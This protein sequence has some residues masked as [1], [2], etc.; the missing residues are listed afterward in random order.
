MSAICCSYFFNRGIWRQLSRVPKNNFS[1]LKSACI[2][3]LFGSTTWAQEEFYLKTYAGY[4]D[5]TYYTRGDGQ[6]PTAAEI[7]N[8]MGVFQDYLGNIYLTESSYV[9]Q[10]SENSQLIINT[11]AGGGTSPDDNGIPATS[12][13]LSTP[14]G[15]AG[16]LIGNIYFS[17]ST[18]CTVRYI[19]PT[20]EIQTLLG[21][22]GM[23]QGGGA[24]YLNGPRGLFCDVLASKLYI[25]DRLNYVVKSYDLGT[26]TIDVVLGSGV[27]GS[28]FSV[29][30]LQVSIRPNGVFRDRYDRLFVTD[31]GS[32]RVII[33]EGGVASILVGDGITDL[34][35]GDGGPAALAT[36]SKSAAVCV[37]R[38]DIVY[39]FS[40][41]SVR[42]VDFSGQ[43]DSI[44]NVTSAVIAHDEM[45][46]TVR[47]GSPS[48]CFVTPADEILF[49]DST[50]NVLWKL[51]PYGHSFSERKLFSVV[52]YVNGVVLP[53]T[54]V[55]LKAIYGVWGDSVGNIYVTDGQSHRVHRIYVDISGETVISVYAGTGIG[56]YNGDSKAASLAS[57]NYPRAI[58][59]NTNGDIFIA[60]T[61]GHRIRSVSAGVIRTIAGTG[62]ASTSD[63]SDLD[64]SIASVT[65]IKSPTSVSVSPDG[66]K[67]FFVH[68]E[69]SI[70]Y[71]NVMSDELIYVSGSKNSGNL[72]TDSTIL[73]AR[74]WYLTLYSHASNVLFTGELNG[75]KVR[76]LNFSIPIVKLLVGNPSGVPLDDQLGTDTLLNGIP[77]ICGV[78]KNKLYF[79][80]E[81]ANKIRSLDL[82]TNVVTTLYGSGGMDF[83]VAAENSVV[84]NT[85]DA[86]P[87]VGCHYS[88]V[89]DAFY[90]TEFYPT[91]SSAGRLRR[92]A[93]VQVP[94]SQPSSKP[95]QQPSSQPTSAPT[96]IFSG[97]SDGKQVY[98]HIGYNKQRA[99]TFG[100]GEEAIYARLT[101]FRDFSFDPDNN[102]V[103]PD[104]LLIRKLNPATGIISRVAGGGSATNTGDG[105]DALQA[106][107]VN[108]RAVTVDTS[109]NIYY[110]ENDMYNRVRMLT[111]STNVINTIVGSNS[112]SDTGY[113]GDSGA[114]TSAK[115]NRPWGIQY[116]EA[117]HTLFIAEWNNQVIR[118]YDIASDL[119]STIAGNGSTTFSLAPGTTTFTT[120]LNGPVDVWLGNDDFVYI[121]EYNGC[122]IAR[123][124]SFSNEIFRFAGTGVC[125]DTPMQG[126]S[127][128]TSLSNPIA[129]CGDSLGNIYIADRV[130]LRRVNGGTGYMEIVVSNLGDNMKSPYN[131][132]L[133][134]SG[135]ITGCGVHKVTGTL[136][137]ASSLRSLLKIESPLGPSP[138]VEAVVGFINPICVPA[139][140][141]GL[142]FNI[143]RIWS[144][145]V[146]DMYMIE[147]GGS[148]VL[149]YS[150]AFDNVCVFAGL[151]GILTVT[152]A[153]NIPATSS[154]LRQ[155]SALVG[156]VS[157][158]IYV[159][160]YWGNRIR[161]IAP[162][163]II[164]T[165][166]GNVNATCGSLPASFVATAYAIC[167]P[168][169]LAFHDARN[170]LYFV[171]S[172][173]S[174]YR[175]SLSTG[176]VSA[177]DTTWYTQ[178]N[179]VL[180]MSAASGA[181]PLWL[182]PRSNNIFVLD[183]K[184]NVVVKINVLANTGAV[185]AA[186][187]LDTSAPIYT[188][189]EQDA[190][191]TQVLR[192]LSICG[193][194][195]GNVY[196]TKQQE[197]RVLRISRRT[198]KLSNY[199]GLSP[200]S[201]TI[202][203]DEFISAASLINSLA[204]PA[205]CVMDSVGDFYY[206]ESHVFYGSVRHSRIRRV[207][208]F[209]IPSSQPTTQPSAAPSIRDARGY[210]AHTFAGYQRNVDLRG[211]GGPASAV[212]LSYPA[213]MHVSPQGDYYLIDNTG[214][215]KIDAAT[216]MI[217]QI[218]GGGNSNVDGI[219][220][221]DTV[222][223][224]GWGI[225]RDDAAGVVY[226]SDYFA[227]VV[228]AYFEA[229]KRVYTVA[230]I[231]GDMSYRGVGVSPTTTGIVPT[232]IF[233]HAASGRLYI[234]EKDNHV[235]YYLSN[236]LI[237]ILVGIYSAS[238]RT[239]GLPD[240]ALLNS[241]VD[242]WVDDHRNA[243]FIAD[244]D[245]HVVRMFNLT[246]GITST[247]AGNSFAS[248]DGDGVPATVGG[249]KF[250]SSVCGDTIG[251]I[252]VV[253]SDDPSAIRKIDSNSIIS[254]I[255]HSAQNSITVS[256]VE[257]GNLMMGI[258]AGCKVDLDGSLLVGD[259]SI[260]TIWRIQS[261]VLPNSTAVSVVKY[262]PGSFS[263]VPA[264]SMSFGDI[265]S[266]WYNSVSDL[267]F[268][269][270]CTKK[271]VYRIK[272]NG[273]VLAV[274]GIGTDEGAST[275]TN[276][277]LTSQLECPFGI[278]GDSIGN[279]YFS[280]YDANLIRSFNGT[281][282]LR[283]LAGNNNQCDGWVSD[284]SDS[285]AVS[286]CRPMAMAY[287]GSRSIYFAEQWYFI[288]R[289]DLVSLKLFTMIGTGSSATPTSVFVDGGPLSAVALPDLHSLVF[290]SSSKL[291]FPVTVL[292]I[293]VLADIASNKANLFAG[294][295]S[296]YYQSTGSAKAA[297]ADLRGLYAVCS[298]STRVYFTIKGPGMNSHVKVL[299]RASDRVTFFAG[300]TVLTDGLG[301]EFAPATS[302]FITDIGAC[303]VDNRGELYFKETVQN[304]GG[305][306]TS[307][308]VNASLA[309]SML[310]SL[311]SSLAA[312]S[313]IT[314]TVR[315]VAQNLSIPSGGVLSV[316]LPLSAEEVAQGVS[317][318][319][320]IGIQLQTVITSSNSSL[321]VAASLIDSSLWPSNGSSGGVLLPR[322]GQ[323]SSD[324]VVV[325]V[326]GTTSS[327]N[328]SF[329]DIGFS[330]SSL[331]Q[332]NNTP[333]INFTITCPPRYVIQKSFLCND[334]GYIEIV[335]C[336][337]IPGKFRGTCPQFTQQ[338]AALNLGN[339]TI[340]SNNMCQTIPTNTTVNDTA[341]P[342]GLL[343]RCGI[344]TGVVPG[345]G[346]V[347][348]GVVLGLVS[349]DFSKTFQASSAF[350]DG[351]A[352]SKA[353]L[354]L[355]LFC[356]IWGIA[357]TVA[358]YFGSDAW[359]W[360]KSSKEA[361]EVSVEV[362][363]EVQ[364]IVDFEGDVERPPE[365][366]RNG[367]S[368]SH[369]T[370]V[371]VSRE[372]WW[373]TNNFRH[374]PA[375]LSSR[376][377]RAHAAVLYREPFH[378]SVE[379]LE[380][381]ISH[382][383]Q[384][385]LGRKE[386]VAQQFDAA[387]LLDSVTGQ[388]IAIANNKTA[389]SVQ[390]VVE[391][392]L[393]DADKAAENIITDM[394]L[395]ERLFRHMAK[396]NGRVRSTK[397]ADHAMAAK[398]SSI[399]GTG[400]SKGDSSPNIVFNA[401]EFLFVSY[402]VAQAFPSLLESE[403]LAGY[404]TIWP[405]ARRNRWL[406]TLRKSS[407]ETFA[408][409]KDTNVNPAESTEQSTSWLRWMLRLPKRVFVFLALQLVIYA[410]LQVQSVVIRIMEPLVLSGLVLLFLLLRRHPAFLAVA[411]CLVLLV[412]LLALWDYLK[413]KG[414][415]QAA[416]PHQ[417]EEDHNSSQ[418]AVDI[419]LPTNNS[420]EKIDHRRQL[421]SPFS[422]D[423][424]SESD[425][426]SF[427]SS[428]SDFSTLRRADPTAED[429]LVASSPPSESSD[430]E[431]SC[432]SFGTESDIDLPFF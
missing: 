423:I 28:A 426:S 268:F 178:L 164:T 52:G 132:S 331:Q 316:Q 359:S 3:F 398:E 304:S 106:A 98:T 251:N 420:K 344:A 395:L 339:L 261:P 274:A 301:G 95:S 414:K 1:L 266:I 225:T 244:F 108:V 378:R 19:T 201:T 272:R 390:R 26:N 341:T 103:L 309:L 140:K 94:T 195:S 288:R 215:Y 159:A 382:Q 14:W 411:A 51:E 329:V 154:G 143:V 73:A 153:D 294:S 6:L 40:V 373:V 65:A 345:T 8:P 177:I 363:Q 417:C 328:V 374:L 236:G 353:G 242:I 222:I 144:N 291:L 280:D 257:V 45:A 41:N 10:I 371:V 36:V 424:S 293:T 360:S 422:S 77:S 365:T 319:P 302:A 340:A 277:R 171:D 97:S 432:D 410:P 79:V 315:V 17:D 355:S 169:G 207:S 252:Y 11:I 295:T 209:L 425:F 430:S 281:R 285:L 117:H 385:L 48:G 199:L 59:G 418:Q 147:A 137:F 362:A 30:P 7:L 139:Y 29:D 421:D 318:V 229:T 34:D 405:G 284:D 151:T 409:F 255:T 15:I 150:R 241:P 130:S 349:S 400:E 55:R 310:S 381:C 352:A 121:A 325:S 428:Q 217:V 335:Q 357:A 5:N 35:A 25:A 232:G 96:D 403:L 307:G 332:F 131:A 107:V 269:T 234:A 186:G 228:R 4:L 174:L 383:R 113:S 240:V 122:T 348:A 370:Q 78:R 334:T 141:A 81:A 13:Q 43:I 326:V 210:L 188:L 203:S 387:W 213:A 68:A 419:P 239:D 343:C 136:Y 12:A 170:E 416:L 317:S 220:G 415:V 305:Q 216:K 39:I 279:I 243:L 351:S 114:G 63:A 9:R 296:G 258:S 173:W 185:I 299:D 364:P 44:V 46:N 104:E 116:D 218:V 175:L 245:N 91:T 193:D 83:N 384:L 123:F 155:A 74:Y 324:I 183:T 275:I 90:V 413:P 361:G 196:I 221:L 298:D 354:V 427:V 238:G 342:S 314:D 306:N 313:L 110:V 198:G 2:V 190:T 276:M 407:P 214:V 20:Q 192:M 37:D 399:H 271:Q 259:M 401:A 111:K 21:I 166:A 180:N 85:V 124:N 38:N 70:M 84:S 18:F 71:I 223:D 62:V 246:S 320:S 394:Q 172:A 197:N 16:D 208:S 323:L 333:R 338:C 308:N 187:T 75:A 161:V 119:V 115:L 270:D 72:F 369:Q 282:W 112:V 379:S 138:T 392:A 429:R 66:T 163:G 391:V 289:L 50:Y 311:S 283:T 254:T 158:N 133:F 226:Y 148:R 42:M 57:L 346:S 230:G 22:R 80:E 287:D 262:L 145:S 330:S 250:P 86:S 182:D 336:Q 31:T 263:E 397:R 58:T 24:V 337:G 125:S 82:A 375:F 286:L 162:N 408:S 118:T 32:P 297:F 146:G 120:G 157:G 33:V 290:L 393:E 134:Y 231:W 366:V 92:I 194:L 105:F 54:T 87:M 265:K 300:G 93:V 388:F 142:L 260:N 233:H 321:Y 64:L 200:G 135:P 402:R 69:N 47:V 264:T 100:D 219:L 76:A 404:H 160:E 204:T 386:S 389:V 152:G 278:T 205:A 358:L 377:L 224:Q 128:S 61:H 249:L 156:D 126:T 227:C 303:A 312:V 206:A 212:N 347:A 406:R 247:F 89:E 273:L 248:Y 167:G 184:H 368:L 256:G 327:V 350:G 168:C 372:S 49:T 60:E 431:S 396:H 189:G 27:S 23:C 99:A 53:S 322:S 191:N 253:S 88:H 149:K 165:V 129:V 376:A 179:T 176:M 181:A 211:M 235:V 202:V 102:I 127:T 267:W 56:T 380:V 237:H 412:L 292:N 356:G 367:V 67:I 109:G 101:T